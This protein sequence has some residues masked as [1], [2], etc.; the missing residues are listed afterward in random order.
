MIGGTIVGQE[1]VT[2]ARHF[3]RPHTAEVAPN[4][5][6][7]LYDGN[8]QG[9]YVEK[10]FN[11]IPDDK[12]KEMGLTILKQYTKRMYSSDRQEPIRE[13]LEKKT[14]EEIK[15]AVFKD[16]VLK[17]MLENSNVK[18]EFVQSKLQQTISTIQ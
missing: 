5:F 1:E 6:S 13:Y 7:S 16:G 11:V 15:G 3:T 9:V 17:E 18:A 2:K 8:M 14:S 4:H 12:T 10:A